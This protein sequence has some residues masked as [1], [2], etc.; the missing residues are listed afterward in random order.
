MLIHGQSH[1]GIT[2][3]I[4]QALWEACIY[5]HRSGQLLSG[6]F[7][8]YAMRRAELLEHDATELVQVAALRRRRVEHI[9][10]PATPERVWNAVRAARQN[11]AAGQREGGSAL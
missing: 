1:G 6:S 10:L 8:D 3:G 2:Q 9:E 5:D 7:L 4:G 11:S